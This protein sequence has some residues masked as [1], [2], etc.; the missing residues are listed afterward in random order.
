MTRSPLRVDDDDAAAGFDVIEDHVGHQGGFAGAGGAEQVD[1]LPGVGDGQ[2]DGVAADLGPAEDLHPPPAGRRPPTGAGMALARAR[3][4]PGTA[5]SC[6]SAGDGGQFRGGQQEPAA[7]RPAGQH[8]RRVPAAGA[9][10]ACCGPG[11]PRTLRRPRGR[12]WP[13]GGPRPA[14]RQR[15]AGWWRGWGGG[16]CWRPRTGWPPPTA[17]RGSCPPRGGRPGP[18]TD[19]PPAATAARTAGCRGRG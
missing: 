2:G 3:S 6:G 19:P 15:C 16:W 12:G 5:R 11:R 1:V 13:G 8:R 18:A 10:A 7:Q 14:R 17:R 4:R 9:G